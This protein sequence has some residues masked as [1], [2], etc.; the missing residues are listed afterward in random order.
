MQVLVDQLFQC[1]I[2]E[3]TPGG[4]PTMSIIGSEELNKKF[5]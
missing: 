1:T 5:K 4:K 2:P 3:I